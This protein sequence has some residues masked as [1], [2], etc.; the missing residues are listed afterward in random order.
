M[1]LSNKHLGSSFDEHMLKDYEELAKKCEEMEKSLSQIG[2]E[3]WG[4]IAM[5][6]LARTT[7]NKVR[8]VKDRPVQNLSNPEDL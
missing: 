1:T 2:Y 7:L 6:D 3:I 5:R 4:E 8:D